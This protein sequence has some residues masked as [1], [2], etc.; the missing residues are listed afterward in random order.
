MKQQLKEL[1]DDL[2]EEERDLAMHNPNIKVQLMCS[3]SV[4]YFLVQSAL[5]YTALF[6]KA[7]AL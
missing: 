2:P 1:L 5:E 7:I 3:L 4:M 6:L